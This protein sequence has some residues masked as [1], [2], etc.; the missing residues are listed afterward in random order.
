MNNLIHFGN[1]CAPGISINDILNIKKT[2]VYARSVPF[3]SD[4]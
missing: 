1:S 4:Y 2:I 3:Q